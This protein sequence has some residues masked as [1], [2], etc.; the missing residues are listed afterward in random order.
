MLPDR[1]VRALG[2]ILP[3][4]VHL[5]PPDKLRAWPV[6]LTLQ[7]PKL[8]AKCQHLGA[9]P[10]LVLA[11][12]DQELDQAAEQV[13]EKAVEHD[14]ASIAG[15]AGQPGWRLWA[16]S[17][18]G[19]GRAEEAGAAFNL[20]QTAWPIFEPTG[21]GVTTHLAGT[22]RTTISVPTTTVSLS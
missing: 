4:V 21:T 6:D 11:T 17:A 10:G 16:R 18:M 2:R 19:A 7:H 8:M 15:R 5:R 14:R 12:H 13:V 9:E 3:R 22:S 1:P 20:G